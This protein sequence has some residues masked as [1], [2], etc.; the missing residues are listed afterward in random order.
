MYKEDLEFWVRRFSNLW[1]PK[2]ITY[3]YMDIPQGSAKI[4]TSMTKDNWIKG[5][6]PKN[7]AIETI[8][9]VIT[10]T[11]EGKIDLHYILIHREQSYWVDGDFILG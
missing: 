1:N 8:T 2:D 3:I 11:P 6:N 10:V 5:R 4:T 9:D 7:P